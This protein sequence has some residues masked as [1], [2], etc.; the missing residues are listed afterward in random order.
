VGPTGGKGVPHPRRWGRGLG[1]IG[2]GRPSGRKNPDPKT[3]PRSPCRTPHRLHEIPIWTTPCPQRPRA[4]SVNHNPGTRPNRARTPPPPY[5]ACQSQP[6][7]R[8]H[9]AK[10]LADPVNHNLEPAPTQPGP[11]ADPVNHSPGTRPHLART[12][13]ISARDSSR[14]PWTPHTQPNTSESHGPR[15]DR[16]RTPTRIPPGPPTD[17]VNHRPGPRPYPPRADPAPTPSIPTSLQLL[18]DVGQQ[19]RA[20]ALAAHHQQQRARRLS[21]LSPLSRRHLRAAW[22][23]ERRPR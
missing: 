17:P 19:P 4:D 9:P 14:T 13:S 18:Q 2:E 21:S 22:T 6:G 15:P 8:P 7:A 12:L 5:R 11:S 23:P 10:T 16:C 20:A 1:P 3:P